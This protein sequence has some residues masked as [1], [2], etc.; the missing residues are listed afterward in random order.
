MGFT[1]AVKTCLNK[2]TDFSGRAARPEFWYFALF[3]MILQVVAEI[4]LSFSPTLSTIVT[5]LIALGLLLPMIAV[6][7][8]R[9]HDIDKSGWWQL[10]TLVP[11]LG[12]IALLVMFCLKGT[13][14]P[15]RFDTG[16]NELFQRAV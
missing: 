9:L 11:V 7:A 8:R 5:G 6:G 15:N 2:Y 3:N 13:P 16:A 10:I 12:A 4:V 1:D 14:G